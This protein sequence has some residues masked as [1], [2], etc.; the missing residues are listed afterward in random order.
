[1]RESAVER[2]FKER[3]KRLGGYTIKSSTMTAGMPDRIVLLPG[4]P[5]MLVELKQDGKHRSDIQIVWHDRLEAIG[6]PV[7][8]LTGKAE[9]D[10]WADNLSVK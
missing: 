3:V 1:M 4:R 10:E 5:V 6:H 2:R 9:V 7:L 8:T